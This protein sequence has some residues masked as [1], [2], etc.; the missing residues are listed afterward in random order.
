MRSGQSQYRDLYLLRSVSCSTGRIEPGEL[1]LQKFPGS[2]WNNVN[3]QPRYCDPHQM[4]ADVSNDFQVKLLLIH[5]EQRSLIPFLVIAGLHVSCT[6]IH[7][8]DCSF[9]LFEVDYLAQ[10]L[11]H[12]SSLQMPLKLSPSIYLN[13]FRSSSVQTGHF[14]STVSSRC[15]YPI[16]PASLDCKGKIYHSVFT[17]PFSCNVPAKS[18]LSKAFSSFPPQLALREPRVCAERWLIVPSWRYKALWRTQTYP[19]ILNTRCL[20]LFT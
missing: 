3:T 17:P 1:M 8:V 7:P 20:Q 16:S 18:F 15:M 12:F 10:I 13:G 6:M 14:S 2:N 11:F 5:F 19:K 9:S 4:T